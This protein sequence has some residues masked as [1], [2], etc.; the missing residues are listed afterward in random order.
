[1]LTSYGI[2]LT[3]VTWESTVGGGWRLYGGFM[4]P[5][6]GASEVGAADVDVGEI[7]IG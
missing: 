3:Q 2:P 7:G 4:Q 1:M 5:K 6:T